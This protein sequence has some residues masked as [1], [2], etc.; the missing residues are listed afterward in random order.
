MESNQSSK[1]QSKMSSIPN[2]FP[3]YFS[4]ESP[5]EVDESLPSSYMQAQKRDNQPNSNL[6]KMLKKSSS[7]SPMKKKW[8]QK[9]WVFI[10]K[11][12]GDRSESSPKNL[13]LKHQKHKFTRHYTRKI[14]MAKSKVIRKNFLIVI[15]F[16]K[17]FIQILKTFAFLK[18]IFRLKEFHFNL[19]GD[20][21][22]QY[23]NGSQFGEKYFGNLNNRTSH[24][25]VFS[26][27]HS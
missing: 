21:S 20:I 15:C 24:N 27:N 23:T 3:N 22:N 8:Y 6:F 18:K 25:Y 12:S 9:L 26:L 19:I 7:I 10:N 14:G 4:H 13:I 2:S 17:K 1:N 11:K 16:V 5:D